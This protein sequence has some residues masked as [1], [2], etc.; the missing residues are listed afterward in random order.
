MTRVDPPASERAPRSLDLL[1]H[2]MQNIARSGKSA[3][4]R[5][6]AKSILGQAKRPVWRPSRKQRAIME[7]MVDEHFGIRDEVNVIEGE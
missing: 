7:N 6:F 4:A 1:L 3:W 5:N 2:D